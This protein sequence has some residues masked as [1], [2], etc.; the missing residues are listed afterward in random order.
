[1]DLKQLSYFLAVVEHASFSQA[2][3]A[4]QVTQPALSRQVRLLEVELRQNLLVR[5]GRGVRC[6][7]A[8][9]MMAKHA[10]LMLQ[11]AAAAQ[12]EM[13]N[14]RG[15]LSGHVTIGIPTSLSNLLTVPLIDRL[16]AELPYATFSLSDGLSFTT[17]ELLV[18]KRLDIALLYEPESSPQL[19]ATPIME[20]AL[21]LICSSA[22]GG[23]ETLPVTLC[24]AADLPLV[25]P[26]RPHG[27]RILVESAMREVHRKPKICMEADSVHM[28]L[29]FLAMKP[30]YAIL[31]LHSIATYASLDSFHYRRIVAPDLHSRL[32]LATSAYSPTSPT[33]RAALKIVQ[34][35]CRVDL[36]PAIQRLL[37]LASAKLGSAER[38]LLNPCETIRLVER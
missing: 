1:M 25:I 26:R 22:S 9:E 7:E 2:S 21:F 35:S 29:D 27:I 31:P 18:D 36:F 16:R 30:G 10:R 37:R 34:D 33:K 12:S 28:I 14:L 32:F 20:Q 4:L 38:Q 11:N 24:E 6:T 3:R 23:N 8:G 19:D 5:T 15:V 13:D 17:Q